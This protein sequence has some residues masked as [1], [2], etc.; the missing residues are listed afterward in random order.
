M[1]R[2]ITWICAKY[3]LKALFLLSSY[4]VSMWGLRQIDKSY[5]PAGIFPSQYIFQGK[6]KKGELINS[7]DH[8]I[9]RMPISLKSTVTCT[10]GCL[11]IQISSLLGGVYT[12]LFNNRLCKLSKIY[13]VALWIVKEWLEN[14]SKSIHFVSSNRECSKFNLILD[15]CYILIITS[16]DEISGGGVIFTF[17]YIPFLF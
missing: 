7:I 5:F 17:F 6:K 4:S 1:K 9:S 12:V 10:Q 11:A 2:P 16:Q 8:R 3:F 13:L 14:I 15:V